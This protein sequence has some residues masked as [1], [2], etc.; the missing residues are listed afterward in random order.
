[1]WNFVINIWI[2][3]LRPKKVF[4]R[5]TVILTFDLWSSLFLSEC[6]IGKKGRILLHV[7]LLQKG[8]YVSGSTCS[9]TLPGYLRWWSDSITV[10]RT[11][12]WHFKAS[13]F[14]CSYKP[15]EN[16]LVL[17]FVLALL[18]GNYRPY[19]E[20]KRVMPSQTHLIAMD[21]HTDTHCGGL[22]LVLRLSV[23]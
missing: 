13:R 11:F 20:R 9:K 6:C 2:C 18:V 10:Y 15:A 23:L 17:A 14:I 5:F 4:C 21:T 1:M 16:M 7:K 12:F 19:S 3:Q 22:R 8:L